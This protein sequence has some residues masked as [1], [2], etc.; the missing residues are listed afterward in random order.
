MTS[1]A[2]SGI[3]PNC[4]NLLMKYVSLT[5][6]LVLGTYFLMCASINLLIWEVGWFIELQ[7]GL[8][9]ISFLLR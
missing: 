8:P 3:W 5:Y 4:F 1:K 2:P 9:G 6:D 7:I